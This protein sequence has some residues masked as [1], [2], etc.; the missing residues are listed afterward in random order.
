MNIRMLEHLCLCLNILAPR[1]LKKPLKNTVMFHSTNIRMFQK[2]LQH[3]KVHLN[4][5]HLFTPYY[6]Y[7]EL[8]YCV[9]HS[10]PIKMTL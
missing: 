2:R 6:F 10:N 1:T 4:P 7:P 3:S 9:E 8:L 5:I